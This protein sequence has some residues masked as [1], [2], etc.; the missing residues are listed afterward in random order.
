MT[1]ENPSSLTDAFSVSISCDEKIS[2]KG[3]ACRVAPAVW[4][5]VGI[6]SV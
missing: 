3:M 2:A 6:I 1:A 4:R 5:L